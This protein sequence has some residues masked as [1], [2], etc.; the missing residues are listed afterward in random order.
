MVRWGAI[1]K[2]LRGEDFLL[3]YVDWSKR[4]QRYLVIA[5]SAVVMSAGFA[6]FLYFKQTEPSR[7]GLL[8]LGVLA[9]VW[10]SATVLFVFR[11]LQ[12]E[13]IMST[14]EDLREVKL[15]LF[16]GPESDECDGGPEAG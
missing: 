8:V 14:K 3:R 1:G 10:G 15:S 4:G 7:S 2:I 12:K 13:G 9:I 6:W 11:K 16:D 5:L